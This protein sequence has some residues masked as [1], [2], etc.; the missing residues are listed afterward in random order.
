MNEK[1][2]ARRR[3]AFLKAL[4]AT[5]NVTVA[6]ERA[7]VTRSWVRRRR[8]ADAAFDAAC[9]A[10]VNALSAAL[11]GQAANAP[12]SGWGHLDGAELVV[13]GCNRRRVQIA[14]ARPG[15][16]SPAVEDRFLSV[17]AAT[18]SVKAAC[19]EAGVSKSAFYGHRKRWP[20]FA[21]RW[22]AAVKEGYARSRTGCSKMPATCFRVPI[23]R[24]K[25]RSR[26]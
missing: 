22:E 16:I 9:V 13:R 3:A 5:G 10:A 19:R 11:A 2:E 21:A 4:A 7:C 15:Q 24:R 17:P 23:C 26:R 6:A 8:K 14:R 1:M 18:C 25:F 12:A 20:G